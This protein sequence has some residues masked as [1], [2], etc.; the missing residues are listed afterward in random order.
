MF[1]ETTQTYHIVVFIGC[2]V[3]L[4]RKFGILI[5]FVQLNC[6]VFVV[7]IAKF[8][9]CAQITSVDIDR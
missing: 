7:Q 8:Q 6:I 9:P 4:E 1:G 2:D 3:S 5:F